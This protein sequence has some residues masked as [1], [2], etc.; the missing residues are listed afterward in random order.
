MNDIFSFSLSELSMMIKQKKISPL[1]ITLNYI[2]KIKK[3]NDKLNAFVFL[4]EENAINHAKKA[5]HDISAGNLIGNLIW[6]SSI[7]PPM[8]L[9]QDF[10]V[11]S[12]I[13]TRL[14]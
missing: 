3:D 5:T 8:V 10:A 7:F 12:S 13:Q 14:N 4:N 6:M 1:E 11:P 2:E 9:L